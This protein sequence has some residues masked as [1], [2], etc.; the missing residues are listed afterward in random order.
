MI[1]HLTGEPMAESRNVLVE[2]A[3]IARGDIQPLAAARAE[4]LDALIVHGGFGAAKNLS[5]F[6]S[7]GPNA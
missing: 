1:N 2:A 5:N 6:A 4:D 3:R 7:Q